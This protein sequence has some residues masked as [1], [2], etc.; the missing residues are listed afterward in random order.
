MA[1]S[2]PTHI[3]VIGATGNIGKF[4]TDGLIQTNPANAKISIFTSKETA[5]SKAGLLDQWKAAGVDVLIGDIANS[6]DVTRCYHDVDTVVSCLGRNA[7]GLQK[8]LI[9]LAEESSSI[10]RFFPSEYGTD[11]EHNPQ[12]AEEK[13]HQM[14]LSVRKYIRENTKRLRVTYVVVGPYFEMWVDGGQNGSPLGGF[15]I[16]AREATLIS[17]G[18]GLIGFTTMPECVLF[19]Q[20]DILLHTNTYCQQCWESCRCGIA[21]RR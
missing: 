5:L 15:D 4:I 2:L 14:K 17:D 7:L 12:S 13:P 10:Q 18:E 9:R 3:L 6:V 1:S 21:T 19:S 11:I 20:A 8:E 16:K